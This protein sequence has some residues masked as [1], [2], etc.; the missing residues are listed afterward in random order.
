MLIVIKVEW[1]LIESVYLGREL[2]SY[3]V[4]C[5]RLLNQTR[6]TG[7]LKASSDEAYAVV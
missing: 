1:V 7:M 5:L 2:C 3:V 6:F 4:T